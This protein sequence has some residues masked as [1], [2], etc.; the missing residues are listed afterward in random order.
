MTQPGMTVAEPTGPESTPQRKDSTKAEP[1]ATAHNAV[2]SG[3]P[4]TVQFAVAWSDEVNPIRAGEQ[5]ARAAIDSLECPVK[6]VVFYAYY[7]DPDFVPDEGSQATACKADLAAEQAV[8]AAV[9]E[10]CG[11]VPSLGCRARCLTNGGTLVK[12]SV[13]V[14]AIGGERASVAAAAVPILDDRRQSG[15]QVAEVVKVVKDLSLVLALAEM[16]LSF[17]AKEGVSVE[18]FIRGVLDNCPE[19]V[20]LFGGNSMPD[21]MA[22]K[23]LAGAQFFAGQALKGY[24]VVL[25]IGGPVKAFGNHANEFRPCGDIVTV[26]ETK[27][28]WIV[29]LDDQPAMEVYR[30]LRG[31]AVEDKLTSDWQHPIGVVIG[32]E[33]EY[34]RMILNWVDADGKDKDGQPSDLPPGSLCFVAP[35]VDGTKIRILGGGD[36]ARAIVASAQLG[37]AETLQEASAANAEPALCLLSNCCCRGM[38]LRTFGSGSDDEVTEAILPAMETEFP[39]FGFYAWGELGRIKGEYQDLSHQYQ[40]HTFVS[41]VLAITKD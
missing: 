2:R 16:R 1:K 18:D 11:D 19:G 27:D 33:K 37:M 23:D 9:A 5:A 30:K 20:S 38:R 40:Q 39:L 36:D 21:D 41:A 12:N 34:L 14:L 8:A 13:A 17:E 15:R 25:G 24:I 28:K 3:S 26:T 4:K 32:D 29:T 7:Q 6:A 31:M 22:A 10:A 35:V